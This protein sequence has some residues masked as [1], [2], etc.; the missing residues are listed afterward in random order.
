ML[1]SL[2]IFLNALEALVV[3]V[4]LHKNINDLLYINTSIFSIISSQEKSPDACKNNGGRFRNWCRGGNV[5]H[6]L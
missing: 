4:L 5:V 2:S 1:K 3:S 6:G